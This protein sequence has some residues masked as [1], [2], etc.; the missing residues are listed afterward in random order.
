[1]QFKVGE[2]V[3]IYKSDVLRGGETATV[4]QVLPSRC[5]IPEYLVEFN[6][7]PKKVVLR[8]DRF[9]LCIYREE[10]LTR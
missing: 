5:P 8:D 1:M 3:R 4:K 2:K 7:Y 6:S 10:Q 9:L